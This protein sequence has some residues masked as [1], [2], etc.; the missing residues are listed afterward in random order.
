MSIPALSVSVQG[1]G[2]LSSDQINTFCQ[3]CDTIAQLRAFV[4]VSGIQVYVRGT[5]AP[6]DGGQGNWWWN[7]SLVGPTDNNFSVIVPPAAGQGAWVRLSQDVGPWLA[8]STSYA[9]DAA[10][11]AGAVPVGGL[12]RNGSVIQI[13]VS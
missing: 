12:Y 10:A 4:P 3:T 7:A 8:A 13:R 1:Q 9:N 6:N 11:A 2:A 5:F